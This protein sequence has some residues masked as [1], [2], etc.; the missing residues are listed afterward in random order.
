MKKIPYQDKSYSDKKRILREYSIKDEI[1]Y[2]LGLICDECINNNFRLSSINNNDRSYI[3]NDSTANESNIRPIFQD[4]IKKLGFDNQLTIYNTFR[5]L[6]IDGFLVFEI[7]WDDK[8]DNIISFNRLSPASLVPA[9]NKENGAFWIQYPEDVQSKRMLLDSQVIFISYSGSNSFNEEISYVE[10]LM[11]PYNQ[12]ETIENCMIMYNIRISSNIN[13]FTIPVKGLSKQRAEESIGSLIE[14]YKEEINIDNFTGDVTVNGEKQI[15]FNKNVFLPE[16]DSGKTNLEEISSN[17]V[18]HD[19]SHTLE[20]FKNKLR[21]AS[22]LPS[23]NGDLL[24]NDTREVIRL[25]RFKD[26]IKANFIEIV[27]KPL[28]LQ[29]EKLNMNIDNCIIDI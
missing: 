1:S 19:F 7:I 28:R 22:Y 14:I 16:G 12:L 17:I 13:K 10:R 6:M 20:Y 9:Y 24:Y 18:E 26:R 4:I 11:K 27:K 3:S 15:P 5:D 25:N 29:A 21:Q 23:V 8:K 2:Y